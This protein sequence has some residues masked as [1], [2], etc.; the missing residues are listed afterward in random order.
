MCQEE[1]LTKTKVNDLA[2]IGSQE[3]VRQIMAK[4]ELLK[5]KN[6]ANWKVRRLIEMRRIV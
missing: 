3:Q 6:V 5:R 4:W 1:N 2:L